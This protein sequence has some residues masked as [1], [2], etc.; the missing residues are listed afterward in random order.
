M[1]THTLLRGPQWVVVRQH[2]V[3]LWT[4]LALLIAVA[5]TAAFLQGWIA[6][7][8]TTQS[9][10]ANGGLSAFLLHSTTVS[11]VF[12]LL[13]GAFVAGPMVAR[14][15][16]S[17]TYKLLLTQSMTATRWLA[18]RIALATAVAV[19]GATVLVAT[20]RLG[21]AAMNTIPVWY[22]EAYET[23]GPVPV[24]YAVLGVGIG[25][26]AGLLVR[27]TVPAMGVTVLAVGAVHATVYG[28]LREHLWPVETITSAAE[29]AQPAG[30]QFLDHGMLTA[31]GERLSWRPC[32]DAAVADPDPDPIRC[33]ADRGGVTHFAD[34]HPVSH[35]WPMQLVETC[36]VLALAALAV[37]VA[38][39][40]LRRRYA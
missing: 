4:L 31:T 6:V 37:A 9:G 33:M 19:A 13:V 15:L 10:M 8:D 30:T 16:E 26:L 18:V 32:Y 12:P 23:I 40:V 2:R 25:A 22:R 5:G 20:Y 39:R 14:E 28:L 36:I 38:F 34:T 11:V 1:S 29:M 35:A 7:G 17:G 21:W 24:A 3:P 27:R